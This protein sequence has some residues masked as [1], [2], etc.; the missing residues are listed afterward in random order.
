[1]IVI[2]SQRHAASILRRLRQ[3]FGLTQAEV[4]RRLYADRQTVCRRETGRN[5]LTLE[6]LIC[7]AAVLGFD[8][9]LTPRVRYRKTG[10]GWPE[11]TA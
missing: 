7:T 6:A 10:T 1:V 4:G 5:A 2:L 8:V 3:G 9:A 11:V